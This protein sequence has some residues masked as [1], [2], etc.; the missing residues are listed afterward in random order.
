[1]A[2]KT[3]NAL[4]D[5]Y[6]AWNRHDAE[7]VAASFAEGGVYADPLTR[8]DLSG[9]TLAGHVKSVLDVI[10]D[11]RIAVTR[12]VANE[13]AAAVVWTARGTWDGRLGP[14]TASKTPVRFEGIDVF[15]FE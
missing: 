5:F 11:L 6:D 2:E 10:P 15:E 7:A 3:T 8:F 14:L 1:M 13:N 4:E 9:D 12:T